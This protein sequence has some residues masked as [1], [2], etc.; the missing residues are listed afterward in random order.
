MVIATDH[1][2]L[3]SLTRSSSRYTG[4]ALIECAFLVCV[5]VAV[6]Q[7]HGVHSL[8]APHMHAESNRVQQLH[9]PYCRCLSA[10]Q[11]PRTSAV[12]VR[13]RWL[14]RQSHS[15]LH[16]DHAVH[17]QYANRSSMVAALIM[18]FTRAAALQVPSSFASDA[19][20]PQRSDAALKTV[21][22]SEHI[23]AVRE[24][25]GLHSL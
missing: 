14:M 18:L 25:L 3:H 11:V 10:P 21:T 2:H 5:C 4:N 24:Q 15:G 16:A 13:A 23:I 9:G 19:M 1:W 22:R 17:A 6:V 8:Q 20:T 12:R 7:S